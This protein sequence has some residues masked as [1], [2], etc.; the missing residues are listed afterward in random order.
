[1]RRAVRQYEAVDPSNRSVRVSEISY[2]KRDN[3]ACIP[4]REDNTCVDG[5][6]GVSWDGSLVM[7]DYLEDMLTPTASQISTLLT[8]VESSTSGL[9]SAFSSS[10][11]TVSQE[12]RKPIIVE[13]GCGAGLLGFALNE[14]HNEV[15]VI[16]TD[17]EVDLVKTNL[18][19]YVSLRV[20]QVET[21]D[22]KKRRGSDSDDGERKDAGAHVSRGDGQYILCGTEDS[23]A[24]QSASCKRVLKNHEPSANDV[25]TPI[26]LPLDWKKRNEVDAVLSRVQIESVDSSFPDMIVG[27]EIAVLKKL[28]PWLV[29]T[30]D[31]LAGPQTLV[32][33]SCD[34]VPAAL[35]DS[36]FERSLDDRM[37]SKGFLK[38][39]VHAAKITW[40]ASGSSGDSTNRTEEAVLRDLRPEYQVGNAD[41]VPLRVMSLSTQERA[42]TE[43]MDSVVLKS[44]KTKDDNSELDQHH[45]NM[46]FRAT[47]LRSCRRCHQ[48]FINASTLLN[49]KKYRLF[50]ADMMDCSY[51][52]QYY[53]CRWHPQ[54][55]LYSSDGEG[56][57][58]A[59]NDNYEAK[60]WD[61]CES[62]DPNARGCMRG[63]HEA[64]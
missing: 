56:Y 14:I 64:Y 4:I 45:I 48:S 31:A 12:G 54:E 51:H 11:S 7:L 3:Q 60:F 49:N 23:R 30:I 2:L 59:N 27:A 37:R 55:A 42:L 9:A 25:T 13:L 22:G 19:K 61:C 36:D 10:S 44:Q 35:P 50:S 1:M 34:G 62:A 41:S 43:S 18:E 40:V 32:L 28:Q 16:M 33:L 53:V 24:D 52:S 38:A 63:C 47:A 39:I 17:Q 8:P 5:I 46:Y 21:K 29:D 6:G 15:Q 58:G 20:N 57:Y 26:A